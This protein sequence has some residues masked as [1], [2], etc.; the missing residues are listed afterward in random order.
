MAAVSNGSDPESNF[1]VEVKGSDAKGGVIAKAI[2]F[3]LCVAAKAK[4]YQK[5]LACAGI[6]SC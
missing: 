3:G 1:V 4:Q 5:S 2:D 6:L